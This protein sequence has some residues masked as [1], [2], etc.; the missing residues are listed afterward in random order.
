MA[1]LATFLTHSQ[2]PQRSFYLMLTEARFG[3]ICKTPPKLRPFLCA[4]QN[5]ENLDSITGDAIDHDVRQ[6]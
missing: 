2:I 6:R 4:V 1:L 3:A 5:A